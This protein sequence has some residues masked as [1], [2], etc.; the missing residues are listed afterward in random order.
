MRSALL[1]M[2]A[3]CHS[4][5]GADVPPAR[6]A[7]QTVVWGVND[8]HNVNLPPMKHPA[9]ITFDGYERS[10]ERPV[11]RAFEVRRQQRAK[12]VNALDEVPDSAWF[13][14][15][16]GIRDLSPQEIRNGPIEH[17]GPIKPWTVHSTK[18]GG[19]SK[20]LIITDAHGTKYLIKFGVKGLPEVETGAQI[21]ANRL[22]WACGYNVAEDRVVNFTKKDLVLAPDAKMV[23]TLDRKVRKLDDD[24]LT[25]VLAKVPTEG[26]GRSKLEAKA[27][28][29]KNPTIR[30]VAS[31]WLDGKVV[32]TT[33]PE[34]TRAGDP[35]DRIPHELRR[36]L[37]G[38]YPI[39]SWIGYVDLPTAN[40]LDVEVQ[41]RD[42]PQSHYIRHYLI[43]F[44]SSLGAI[45]VVKNDVRLG[46]AYEFDW[47]DLTHE[48]L[49]LG[50][51]ARPWRNNRQAP[52]L[53]GVSQ[54]WVSEFDPGAW[55][56]NVR[57]APFEA[58]DRFD[59]FWGAKLVARFTREQIRAAVLAGEYTDPRAVDYITDTLV[60]R[61]RLVTTYW[62]SRVNP[63]DRFVASRD[64]LCFDD[65]ALIA[66][67]VPANTTRYML[68]TRDRSGRAIAHGGLPATANGT[69]CV[70]SI[71]LAGGTPDG[72]TIVEIETVRPGFSRTMYVHLA[73]DPATTVPRV[74]GI[75][76]M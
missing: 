11:L 71:E 72:Y 8:R 46:Y 31:R 60:A 17:D 22:L 38:Q 33:P 58:K 66:G 19:A 62:F 13:T 61:Q 69:T 32:G 37:R 42:D 7:N 43:D 20:G 29:G 27:V 59:T 52:D 51:T 30:A 40:F 26:D 5:S 39:Y 24:E 50:A 75:W 48:L 45:N 6:F 10:F 57:Y 70:P 25:R 55:K 1:A 35:N 3:A 67:I 16:I 68:T 47:A 65:L 21:V 9:L 41:N 73:R 44:D 49:T 4:T 2:L 18:F 64:G 34:G 14:N 63:L 15:R 28:M 76:R 23:D 54:V 56:P 53:R 36:D 74:I 12:G